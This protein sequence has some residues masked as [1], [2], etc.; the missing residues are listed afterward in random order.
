MLPHPLVP[1]TV[2]GGFYLLHRLGAAGLGS[3]LWGLILN[4]DLVKRL[5]YDSELIFIINAGIQLLLNFHTSILKP[6]LRFNLSKILSRYSF[7]PGLIQLKAG[8][9]VPLSVS[10][11]PWEN[12][13]CFCPLCATQ[14]TEPWPWPCT[15]LRNGCV[16]SLCCRC[17]C[18]LC[19]DPGART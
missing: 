2:L 16:S 10:H 6:L 7:L 12:A 19:L 11:R 1:S 14:K 8:P 15:E 5:P 17:V 3:V 18:G 4:E 13:V 9:S